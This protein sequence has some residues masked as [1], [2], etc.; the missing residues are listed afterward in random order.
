MPL[1]REFG[2][3]HASVSLLTTIIFV[4]SGV[5]GPLACWLLVRIGA[6]FVMGV[7]AA[8]AGLALVGISYSHNF[9]YFVHLVRGAW[10]WA[11][12]VNLVNSVDSGD[13]LV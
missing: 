4:V 10:G 13:Q 5:I 9:T 2:A 12:R 6:K 7:G 3:T 1:V 8:V 11:R